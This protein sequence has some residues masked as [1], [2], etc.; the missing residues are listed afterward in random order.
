MSTSCRT[1]LRGARTGG[2]RDSPRSRKKRA[3]VRSAAVAEGGARPAPP[4]ERGRTP[5][6]PGLQRTLGER[7]RPRPQG[8]D[9]MTVASGIFDHTVEETHEW[10]LDVMDE[11]AFRDEHKAQRILRA[12][13]HALRDRLTVNEAVQLAAQFPALLR[14][15]YFE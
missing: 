14:G 2:L 9:P 12:V 4:P 7:R 15:F 11:L 10:L 13:L 6:A 8:G 5:L 1:A 3:D